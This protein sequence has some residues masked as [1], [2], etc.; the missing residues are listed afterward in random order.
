MT[1]MEWLLA[2][3]YGATVHSVTC[4][5]S[6][7]KLGDQYFGYGEPNASAMTQL[8]S[9]LWIQTVRCHYGVG[10]T[11]V[12]HRLTESRPLPG[13]GLVHYLQLGKPM[14]LVW[15]IIFL[16]LSCKLS[17][18]WC[19]HL[20]SLPTMCSGLEFLLLLEWGLD[21]CGL[22][23]GSVCGF[24]LSSLYLLGSAGEGSCA[25]L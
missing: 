2:F 4:S 10:T 13:M 20:P 8:P 23:R 24:M 14:A 6:L 15:S 22:G 17:R 11:S 12:V 21:P 9:R 18:I 5:Y 1:I 7:Q 3:V 25:W 19:I 16:Q